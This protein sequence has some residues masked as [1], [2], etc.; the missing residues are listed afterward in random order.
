M[1]YIKASDINRIHRTFSGIENL[2]VYSRSEIPEALRYKESSRT[3]DIVLIAK[4]GYTISRKEPSSY[5]SKHL[6]S[7]SFMKLLI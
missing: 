3:G 1:S 6:N 2:T 7:W 5:L 4:Y